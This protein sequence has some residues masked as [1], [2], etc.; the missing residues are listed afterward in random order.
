MKTKFDKCLDDFLT[1]EEAAEL[2]GCTTQ[3]IR[4]AI[5]EKRLSA[6]RKGR[7]WFIIKSE[8]DKFMKE[9]V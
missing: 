5:K 2:R 7:Q 8:F 3:G 6:E 9:S 4:K 1:V